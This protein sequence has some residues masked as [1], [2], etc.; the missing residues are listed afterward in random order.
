LTGAARVALAPGYTIPRIVKGGWQ[1]AGGH[2]A[3]DREAALSDMFAF[4][5]AGVTCFDCADIYTGV[6]SLIGEFLRRLRVLRGAAAAGIEVHTKFVPDL[7]VLPRLTARDVEAAVDRSLR[8]LGVER[9]D[10]VQLHWWDYDVPGW[11]EAGLTLAELRRKGKLREVGATNFDVPRLAALLEAGVPLVSHQVQ[12]SVVDRRPETGMAARCRA[13]GIG[14][15]AYGSLLGGF[16]SEAWLGAPEPRPPLANRSLTK[17]KLVLE[18]FGDWSA[19]QRLLAALAEVGRRHGVGIGAVALAWTLE[20]PGV[21]AVIVGARSA[22]RLP[23]TLAALA[24]RLDAEDR[25]RIEA[26]ARGAAGPRGDC[27]ALERVKGG[28]HAAVMRYDLNAAATD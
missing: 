17:Y 12:Y 7:A 20:R 21:A 22:R 9:V 5:D 2:G 8:R 18:E 27:Y 28:R 4:L 23:E 19:F 16:L 10:L 6:E 26:V 11:I 3:V 1:L 14:L 13:G 25:E 24:L 15:L